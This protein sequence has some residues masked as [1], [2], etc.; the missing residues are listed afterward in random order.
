MKRKGFTLIE[1]LVVVAIIGI[2]AAVGVVAYNGYTGAA[3]RNAITHQHGQFKRL[4]QEKFTQAELEITDDITFHT[5]IDGS[6]NPAGTACFQWFIR[7]HNK[8]LDMKTLI[9]SNQAISSL[10]NSDPEGSESLYRDMM[11][12]LG[13]R[14]ILDKN[15]A[16][17]ET[18][19]RNNTLIEGGAVFR[20][21]GNAGYSDK[22]KCLLKTQIS[23]SEFIEDV[24]IKNN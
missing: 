16:G 21:G 7:S 18:P 2:L 8:T 20:C 23:D 5:I 15:K 3:K 22:Y 12:G 10:C 14:N 24:L 9:A 13:F 19:G 11:W 17:L 6:G 1:L 4:I